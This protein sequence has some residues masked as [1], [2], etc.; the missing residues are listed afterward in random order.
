VSLQR[1]SFFH[2][3]GVDG[4]G[5]VVVPRSR[6]RRAR[7][8]ILRPRRQS[9][10]PRPGPT[11]AVQLARRTAFRLAKLTARVAPVQASEDPAKV[12]RALRKRL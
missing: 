9:S 2:I 1:V 12:A 7:A 10:A 4:S 6:P 8:H 11:L 5:Y 3:A